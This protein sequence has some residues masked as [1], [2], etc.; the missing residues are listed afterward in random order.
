[1]KTT[2]TPDVVDDKDKHY[3]TPLQALPLRI[4][5]DEDD[6]HQANGQVRQGSE[7]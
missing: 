2:P 1:M 5:D 7:K 3:A 6:S 4:D